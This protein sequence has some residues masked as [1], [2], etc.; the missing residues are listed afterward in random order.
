M[1][2]GLL[3]MLKP[4]GMTSHDV[5]DAV[6]RILR[7]RRVGH[8]G[9]LDPAAAGVM[10]LMLGAVTRLSEYLTGC[11]KVYRAEVTFGITTDTLDGEGTVIARASAA[12]ITP[13]MVQDAL[14][15]LTG[16]VEM[17]PPMYSAIWHE[18]RR[19][20][21]IAREGGTVEVPSRSV[22][23]HR[24]ELLDFQPGE[25][26]SALAEVE[27][28]SGTYVRS[29]AAMLGEALGCPAYLSF[30][31]RSRVGSLSI[32]DALTAQELIQAVRDDRLADVLVCPTAALSAWPRI[33]ADQQTAIALCR[34]LQTPAPTEL[35][36]GQRLLVLT[37]GR[38]L[39]VA[40]VV[41]A[42]GE[43]RIQPRR[44]LM[45]EEELST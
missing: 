35:H 31:V 19:L 12:D 29:L 21:D 2:D 6:R 33:E 25:V 11:D 42:A 9:T 10:V 27:C 18:G 3:S 8:A 1:P 44:V 41:N 28:S 37:S 23:V 4:P 16:P 32:Q 13:E 30:L 45:S 43:A 36:D 22:T 14:A 34:G 26:A 24:F 15:T 39:C 5:V 40:E 17:V 38:L 7:T 20:Y